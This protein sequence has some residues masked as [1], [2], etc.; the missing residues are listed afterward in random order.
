VAPKGIFLNL[1]W[2]S[3]SGVLA[4]LSSN[5]KLNLLARPRVLSVNDQDA[6]VIIG[7]RLGYK[8]VTVTTTGTIEDVK[9]LVVGTQLKIRPHITESGD[10][11]MHINPEVSDGSID[12][13]T[14]L[15]SEKTTTSD[16]KVI[17]KDGQTIVMGGLLRDRV[18]K[19]VD[20]IPLLG[21]LPLFGFF[22]SGTSE[23]K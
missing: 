16:T 18:E 8:T 11:L 20:K 12:P 5:N 13:K 15:P 6:S 10:V 3:V 22:F 19:T 23:T 9:F 17:A 7:S 2:Q 1:S 4:L 14:G 21:D